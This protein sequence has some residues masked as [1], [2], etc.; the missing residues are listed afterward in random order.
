MLFI[1][2]ELMKGQLSSPSIFAKRRQGFGNKAWSRSLSC[3]FGSMRLLR[4]YLDWNV[5]SAAVCPIGLGVLGIASA[6]KGRLRTELL[7]TDIVK[8]IVISVRNS[9]TAISYQK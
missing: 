3:H 5:N 4:K 7:R 1:F 2:G 8:G 9:R 6:S